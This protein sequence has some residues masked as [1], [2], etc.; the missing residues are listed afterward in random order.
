MSS[1]TSGDWRPTDHDFPEDFVP[2]PGV[3]Y[4]V[5][6]NVLTILDDRPGDKTPRPM[7]EEE[8]EQI[9]KGRRRLGLPD[10]EPPPTSP[11]S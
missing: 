2:P 8:K 7:T 11:A 3:R 9:R 10:E 4:L 1:S 5:H 6:G